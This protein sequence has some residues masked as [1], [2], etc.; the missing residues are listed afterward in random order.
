[1]LLTKVG[2]LELLIHGVTRFPLVREVDFG[3]ALSPGPPFLLLSRFELFPHPGKFEL[4]LIAR[5]LACEE[6]LNQR[7]DP[8]LYGC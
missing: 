7:P 1:M 6:I 8:G 2:K 5:N 3:P 4:E